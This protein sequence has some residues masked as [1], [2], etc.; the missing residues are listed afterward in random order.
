MKFFHLVVVVVIML[1]ILWPGEA[2][3]L[4]NYREDCY[5][6]CKIQYDNCDKKFLGFDSISECKYTFT[7]IFKVLATI[8]QYKFQ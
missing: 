2:T 8:R 1:S 6:K 4:E 5:K 7:I 3:W